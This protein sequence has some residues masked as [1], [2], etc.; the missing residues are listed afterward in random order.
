MAPSLK[1]SHE[2]DSDRSLR[3]VSFGGLATAI[4]GSAIALMLALGVPTPL[5]SAAG[6]AV[7]DVAVVSTDA[8]HLRNDATTTAGILATLVTADA[9]T[10]LDGPL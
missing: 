3:L 6:L 8:V 4:V 5:A 10:V 1:T 9:L 2:S 7:G